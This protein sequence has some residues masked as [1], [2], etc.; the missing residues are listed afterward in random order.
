MNKA[1]KSN[2]FVKLGVAKLDSQD[3][4]LILG[5]SMA[6]KLSDVVS[7]EMLNGGEHQF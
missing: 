2:P 3:E 4:G 5:G 7:M 6:S 1:Q